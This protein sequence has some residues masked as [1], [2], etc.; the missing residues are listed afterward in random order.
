MQLEYRGGQKEPGG[1][2]TA[3]IEDIRCE[4]IR[5]CSYRCSCGTL[6]HGIA[7]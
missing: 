5:G 1:P 6:S 3:L 4:K 2:R 7:A